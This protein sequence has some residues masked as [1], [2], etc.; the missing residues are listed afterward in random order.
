MA[1]NSLIECP[2]LQVNERTHVLGAVLHGLAT[3]PYLEEPFTAFELTRIHRC[4]L[5]HVEV[6]PYTREQEVFK[7]PRI[8]LHM[9]P[10]DVVKE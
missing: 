9:Y 2:F 3:G 10:H 4:G 1:D 7:L 8:S 6:G 5:V